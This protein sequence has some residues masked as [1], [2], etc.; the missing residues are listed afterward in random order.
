MLTTFMF[1]VKVKSMSK[2]ILLHAIL[3]KNT[4]I[5]MTL[6][7]LREALKHIMFLTA[8]YLGIL[9]MFHFLGRRVGRSPLNSHPGISPEHV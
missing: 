7:V 8:V 3:S 4:L 2:T 5:H 9:H 6:T 1:N